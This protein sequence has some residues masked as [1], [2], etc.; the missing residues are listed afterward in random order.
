LLDQPSSDYLD[1]GNSFYYSNQYDNALENYFKALKNGGSKEE[2]YFQIGLVYYLNGNYNEAVKYWEE[3]KKLNPHFFNGKIFMIPS[4]SMEPT[5]IKGDHIIVDV[6]YYKYNKIEREDV[7][8]Y[9]SPKDQSS[10]VKRVI[11]LPGETIAIKDKKV[12]VNG[13][14][15]VTVHEVFNDPLIFSHGDGK[16]RDNFG[17]LLL[18]SD[19]FFIM[20]DN[21]DQSYD[22]RFVGPIN[23]DIILGKALVIYC[24]VP[25]EDR[26]FDRLDRSG[27]KIK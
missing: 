3:G 6:H 25:S 18:K 16:V 4:N 1:E 22:S 14:A 5:I 11:G 27:L 23:R 7:V 9:R 12:F 26:L 20:G 8:V 24:S 13:N 21:R 2:I 17:P 15:Y 19:E 10:Y